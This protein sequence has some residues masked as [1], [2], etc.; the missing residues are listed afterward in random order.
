MVDNIPDPEIW[1]LYV[2]A[3]DAWAVHNTTCEICTEVPITEDDVW[4]IMVP[5]CTKGTMIIDT[6]KRVEIELGIVPTNR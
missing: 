6:I 5:E 1:D 3:S 4:R 2:D